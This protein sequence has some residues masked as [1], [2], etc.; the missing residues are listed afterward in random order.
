MAAQFTDAAP[1]L[2]A[3]FVLGLV[4]THVGEW[5]NTIWPR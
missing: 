3:T 5:V 2:A 4:L 1:V